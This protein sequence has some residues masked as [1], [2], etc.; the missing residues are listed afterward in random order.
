MKKLLFGTIFLALVI[1][2]PIP[3]DGTGKYKR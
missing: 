3:N 1:V 2:V